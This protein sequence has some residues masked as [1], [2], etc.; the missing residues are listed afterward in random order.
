MITVDKNK[1][2]QNHKCPATRVCPV[3]AITQEKHELPKIDNT[4][5]IKCKKCITFC[6]MQAINVK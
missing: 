4:L 2:P 3:N 1:C 5:C 6:P